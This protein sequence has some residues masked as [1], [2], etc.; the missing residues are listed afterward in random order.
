MRS[1]VS[2]AQHSTAQR[3]RFRP[4]YMTAGSLA[5]TDRK[6][7]CTSC[8]A[9]AGA[10]AGWQL[11]GNPIENALR[12]QSRTSKIAMTLPECTCTEV[13]E[14]TPSALTSYLGHIAS[15]RIQP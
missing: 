2:T 6:A 14:G 8:S 11:I 4:H 12:S 7:G 3:T 5:A 13:V 9:K 1:V 15:Q 10:E